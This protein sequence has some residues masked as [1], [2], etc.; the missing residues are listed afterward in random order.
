MQM[1]GYGGAGGN[2]DIEYE[3]ELVLE[4][5]PVML[6]RG[7]QREILVELLGWCAGSAHRGD[8]GQ[9][10]KRDEA[11]LHVNHLASICDA[12]RR[13]AVDEPP[14]LFGPQR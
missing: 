9:E 4:K 11:L 7:P 14:D 13:I 8:R 10:D 12:A 3:D 6:G 5:R 1:R 2:G